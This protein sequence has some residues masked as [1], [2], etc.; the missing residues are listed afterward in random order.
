MPRLS[1][2][3]KKIFF[4]DVWLLAAK[5]PH[6]PVLDPSDLWI[7][8]LVAIAGRS[9]VVVVG[10]HLKEIGFVQVRQYR[11]H[12]E[13]LPDIVNKTLVFES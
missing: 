6:H 10:F 4:N 5:K 3:R 2:Y 11:T 9:A 13:V 1:A 8:W 12:S 7:G